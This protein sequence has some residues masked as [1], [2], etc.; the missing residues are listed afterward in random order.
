MQYDLRLLGRIRSVEL[1]TAST[2][3]GLTAL[4]ARPDINK[5]WSFLSLWAYHSAGA[6]RDC[7]WRDEDPAGDV[8]IY[9]TT[10]IA[11]GTRWYANLDPVSGQNVIIGPLVADQ[12]RTPTF[13][14]TAG[15]AAENGTLQAVVLEVDLPVL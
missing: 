9:P 2:G 6:N 3:A 15:G 13:C 1:T 4:P 10:S 5:L 14:W 8:Q 12:Y 11:S 7:Y